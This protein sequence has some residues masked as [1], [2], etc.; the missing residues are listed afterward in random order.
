[1]VALP[2][3]AGSFKCGETHIKRPHTQ[4]TCVTC[5]F[6]VKTSKF[7]GNYAAS[8]WITIHATACNK[9]CKLKVTSRAGCSLTYLQLQVFLPAISGTFPCDCGCF[10]CKLRVSL[11]EILGILTRVCKKFYLRLLVFLHAI[12]M[13]F[14][15]PVAGKFAWVAHEK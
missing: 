14:C 12:C 13:Y 9:A 15:M 5:G 3:K 8:P 11:P 4:C 7:S 6:S 2:A 1:M 10:A